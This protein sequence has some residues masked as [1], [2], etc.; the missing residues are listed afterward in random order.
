M[1]GHDLQNRPVCDEESVLSLI[2]A[3]AIRF[4]HETAVRSGCHS[5]SYT[6]LLSCAL[7]NAD[8]F[9]KRGLLPGQYVLCNIDRGIEL[10]V[11]W[12]TSLLVG[13]VLVPVDTKWP[14]SRL[15]HALSLTGAAAIMHADDA[16][17]TTFSE[18]LPL[19]VDLG[20]RSSLGFDVIPRA[21]INRQIYG[22]FTSGSTGQ[23]K[24]A[25]NHHAGIINRLRYMTKRFGERHIVLQNSSH[26]FDSSIWQIL[27]PLTNGGMLVIPEMRRPTDVDYITEQIETYSVSMTDFV[28]SIIR[29]VAQ[30]L[31][32]ETLSAE[33]LQSLRYVLVGGEE[34]D[35]MVAASLL[36]RLPRTRLINTYGH[37]EASIGMVFHEIT[38]DDRQLVPLGLPIDHT[39]VRICN[40]ALE[41]CATNEVGEIVV[42]G[43]C[44]GDGYLGQPE[45]TAATFIAN[46]FPDIPGKRVYRS[47]DLGAIGPD[48]LLRYHGRRDSQI[49]IRGVRI[50]LGEL[51]A[52]VSELFC[53][54]VE[55]VATA[56]ETL[57]GDR[58]IGLGYRSDDDVSAD[59]LREALR[60]RLPLTHIPKAYLKLEAI[61]LTQNGKADRKRIASL[62]REMVIDGQAEEQTLCAKL[63]A[64]FRRFLFNVSVEPDTDFFASGGDSLDAINLIDYLYGEVGVSVEIA[65]LYGNPTP[66]RLA[67]YLEGSGS[68]KSPADD[69]VWL[70]DYAATRPFRTSQFGRPTHILMTGATGFVGIHLLRSLLTE[71]NAFVSVV[72]RGRDDAEATRH[73]SESAGAARLSLRAFTDRVAVIRGDL[74]QPR[75]G[76]DKDVW[77]RLYDTVDTVLHA[78]ANVNFLSRYAH[79]SPSN[80]EATRQLIDFCSMGRP[81]AF[82]YVSSL[83][84]K[85]ADHLEP[86]NPDRQITLRDLSALGCDGYAMTKIASERLLYGAARAGLP[87]RIY[88]LDDV[89]PSLRSGCVNRRSFIHLL[90]RNCATHDIAPV[91]LG[92]I[93]AIFVDDV[94]ALMTSAVYRPAI[95]QEPGK[96]ANPRMTLEI[97]S[98]AVIDSQQLLGAMADMMGKILVTTDYIAFLETIARRA[99]GESRLLHEILLERIPGEVFRKESHVQH[100]VWDG[101]YHAL[102]DALL[103]TSV[104]RIC[105]SEFNAES[106][107]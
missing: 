59:T 81:K 44:V 68:D 30:A 46:P 12:L 91:G 87:L 17:P 92:N 77:E 74:A 65:S 102:A 55:A 53:S 64:A 85:K 76:V 13:T 72:V 41:P 98:H 6:E 23:P 34:M 82:H 19:R 79:L 8:V 88:R 35:G 73:L 100:A 90:F 15:A 47:G 22:F 38:R 18:T 9:R 60:C 20:L 7:A 4:S 49:K 11:A 107:Q 1:I 66:A 16:L 89:L 97:S 32:R 45:L 14:D 61:P 10:P 50:E 33:R 48:G 26:V 106:V 37:T 101:D 70:P 67:N 31:Q 62:L 58:I 28:P 21:P 2:G 27:W 86:Q 36:E 54:S 56:F 39:F 29:F 57:T 3:S 84:A 71:T 104:Q 99:D 40:D 95:T 80:V 51:E 63:Q 52:V 96:P 78:G 105:R 69:I 75:L 83:V 5:M 93:T 94:A 103:G 24:C 43:V 42:G 25:L